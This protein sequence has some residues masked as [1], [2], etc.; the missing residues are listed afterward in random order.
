M[1][2]SKVLPDQCNKSD[3]SRPEKPL[4]VILH[5]VDALR[6]Y[7]A[8]AVPVMEPPPLTVRPPELKIGRRTDRRKKKIITKH[9]TNLIS[10]LLSRPDRLHCPGLLYLFIPFIFNPCLNIYPGAHHA[11]FTVI[12][13]LCCCV[14]DLRVKGSPLHL[15]M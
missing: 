13:C 11:L 15:C 12:L 7:G 9:S 8:A 1:F 14:N 2:R 6:S 3:R 4:D 10:T 5:R